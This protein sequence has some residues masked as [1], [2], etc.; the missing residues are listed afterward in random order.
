VVIAYLHFVKRSGFVE[1]DRTLAKGMKM[2]TATLVLLASL[3]GDDPHHT[4]H[5]YNPTLILPAK[6][7]PAM[8]L[9]LEIFGSFPPFEFMYKTEKNKSYRV[10]VRLPDFIMNNNGYKPETVI[11]ACRPVG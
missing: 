4:L 3:C 5:L 1:E 9:L 10:R 8:E 11:P 6:T 2:G 7:Q